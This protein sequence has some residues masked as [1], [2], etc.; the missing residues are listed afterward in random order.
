MNPSPQYKRNKNKVKVYAD[1]LK[2][3]EEKETGYEP[4]QVPN[5]KSSSRNGR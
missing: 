1:Y 4:A 3:Y 2:E 5:I